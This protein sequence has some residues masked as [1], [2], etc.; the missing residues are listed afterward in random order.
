MTKKIIII[1]GGPGGYVA[2]I[3]A[4]QLGAQVTV[5]ERGKLGGTCL[6]RGCVP[7][8][9]LLH[10]AR[11][12]KTVQNTRQ[13]GIYCT[14]DSFRY[15]K[16]VEKKNKVVRNNAI[17]I[18]TI[19]KNRHIKLL[20]GIARLSDPTTLKIETAEGKRVK[21]SA[22]ALVIAT[23]SEPLI[24]KFIKFDGDRVITTTEALDLDN[25]P[26]SI[27]I[28]G[29]SVSGCEFA[30][31]F[32]QLG[33]RVYLIEMLDRIVPT[34]DKELSR[35][36]AGR[37]KRLGVNVMTKTRV[38]SLERQYPLSSVTVFTD[39][40]QINADYC[41]LAM[42]R[43]LNTENI[44]LETLGIDFSSKGIKTDKRMQTNVSGVY[45]VGDVTGKYQLAH[46]ASEQGIIAVENIME[47]DATMDYGA[48]PSFIYTDPEIASVGL[49]P[50]EA[51]EKG[52]DIIE[53]KATF[54][55]N[56]MAHVIKQTSGFVK[57]V[58]DKKTLKILG[59]HMFGPHVTELLP[60]AVTM[61]KMDM[62]LADVKNV[63]YPHPTL[64]ETVKESALAAAGE[65]IHA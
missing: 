27:V 34:E 25:L 4:A 31:L 37:L 9:T 11:I 30:C 14:I 51:V 20:S 56:A 6:N 17:G 7:T 44:G 47:I 62:T 52:M 10:A 41:L 58:I 38:E 16:M 12:Y 46:V 43:K 42:G 8:K 65:A 35:R 3:R 63:I 57:T 32:G 60:E 40:D 55:G 64:S 28:V 50:E 36:L 15:D 54:K 26:S 24:P 59:V 49:K 45:A 39:K 1:G 29:G 13:L 2:A 23:G 22:D 19:F 21:E 48:I 61:I 18:E 33:S 53:G 5:V